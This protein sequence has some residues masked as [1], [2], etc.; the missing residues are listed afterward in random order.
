MNFTNL[1]RNFLIAIAL[2][3]CYAL[4]IG[5]G[6][7]AITFVLSTGI[8]LALVERYTEATRDPMDMLTAFCIHKRG[9]ICPKGQTP[10]S[11]T[12]NCFIYFEAPL[13]FEKL[14]ATICDTMY[15]YKR[16][17]SVGVLRSPSDRVWNTMWK[18][19]EITDE[20]KE[21]M[22]CKHE[23]DGDEALYRLIDDLCNGHLP[24]D[25]PQWR[26]DYIEN[27]DGVSCWILR[28]SHG[29]ADGIR[30][31]PIAGEMLQ[32]V[33]GNP[34]GA[35]KGSVMSHKAS[36]SERKSRAKAVRPNWMDP[37]TY[38]QFVGDLKKVDHS[39]N[40][41]CDTLCA[42]KPD[43]R[44]HGPQRQ[45]HVRNLKPL[46]IADVKTLKNKY[47]VSFNDVI[48]ALTV[49]GIR[50]YVLS[51]DADIFKK[52]QKFTMTALL[53]FGFPPK[54]EFR[55]QSDW[56]RNGFTMV[57]W[58]FPVEVDSFERRLKRIHRNGQ[59]LKT[60]FVTPITMGLT[61][62]ACR[63]GLDE[64]LEQNTTKMFARHCCV[65][66]NLPSWDDPLFYDG[67]RVARLEASYFNY[68]PQ[69]IFISHGEDIH[70]TLVVDPERFPNAQIILDAMAEELL[71]QTA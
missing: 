1:G 37:R 53:A 68:V 34:I 63:L 39:I 2:S 59:K 27:A 52:H 67:V 49:S 41:P 28:V 25:L 47:G 40:G 10:T 21:R 13:N 14:K 22:I 15:R 9:V 50:K 62:F 29:V 51:Q 8:L 20:V 35:P 7:T 46:K 61:Q 48:S 58:P 57:D 44:V 33:E 66:S 23:V 24:E 36:G 19:V 31:V 45:I 30:L 43:D 18:A 70:G 42:F 60:S 65:F 56:L 69:F 6:N 4:F 11:M 26:S 16:F 17:S 5:Y 3:L 38:W 54:E 64:L 71:R 32:D 55:G 12:Q